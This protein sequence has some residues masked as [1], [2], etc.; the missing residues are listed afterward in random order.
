MQLMQL[1]YVSMCIMIIP[2]SLAAVEAVCVKL[3]RFVV[4]S[5]AVSVPY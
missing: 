5:A 4:S 3:E 1:G 2:L